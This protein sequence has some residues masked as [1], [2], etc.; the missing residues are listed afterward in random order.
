MPASK[1]HRRGKKLLAKVVRQ[2]QWRALP[3][4]LGV[5]CGTMCSAT[6]VAALLKP[7]ALRAV[8]VPTPNEKYCY[9]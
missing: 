1:L 2:V 5:A 8:L 9:D 4:T 3:L 6:G 7:D